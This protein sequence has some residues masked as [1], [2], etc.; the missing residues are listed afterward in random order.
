MET[1]GLFRR[2]RDSIQEAHGS[3]RRDFTGD[4][5]ERA[6]KREMR[7][8]GSLHPALST[9]DGHYKVGAPPPPPPPSLPRRTCMRSPG[10]LCLAEL[11][12]YGR[13]ALAESNRC[14]FPEVPSDGCPRQ[15]DFVRWHLLHC[16][17]MLK[18]ARLTSIPLHEVVCNQ[19]KRWRRHCKQHGAVGGA[20]AHSLFK[21]A[22]H[23]R[24]VRTYNAPKHDAAVLDQS[25]T[26]ISM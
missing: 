8:D 7:A 22:C 11:H 17:R 24:F 5:W 9:P 14:P 2:T 25:C 23:A 20:S 3:A 10:N 15:K 1:L 18:R 6:L 26:S 16:G 21:Y 19:R 12:L 4:A 13:N